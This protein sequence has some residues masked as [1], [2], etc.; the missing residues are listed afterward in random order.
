MSVGSWFKRLFSTP[1]ETA[2]DDAAERE[3]YGAP[4]SGESALEQ[5]GHSRGVGGLPGI[6][7]L[8]GAAAAEEDLESFEPP[9][10][11]AP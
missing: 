2:E 4:D 5:P 6:A 10:D 11:P 7:G 1:S 9:P 3:D 8:E